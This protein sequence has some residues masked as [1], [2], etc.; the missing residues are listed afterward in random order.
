MPLVEQLR[1]DVEPAL[2]GHHDVEEHNVRLCRSRLED[3]VARSAGLADRFEIVLRV[4]QELEA[5]PHDRMIVH[6]QDADAHRTGTSAAIVVPPP[7]LVSIA[8]R[9]SSSATRSRI[10]TM[11]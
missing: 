10:P 5:R 2:V 4:E 1:E 3:R 9:P 6:D 11:P 7:G 8:I